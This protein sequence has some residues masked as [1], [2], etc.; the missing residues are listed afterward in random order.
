[1]VI[2][3]EGPGSGAIKRV[4]GVLQQSPPNQGAVYYLPLALPLGSYVMRQAWA[5]ASDGSLETSALATLNIEWANDQLEPVYLGSLVIDQRSKGTA[6]K[7]S[8][9]L[10]IQDAALEDTPAIRALVSELKSANLATR[11]LTLPAAPTPQAEGGITLEVSAG[12]PSQTRPT[13]QPARSAYAKFLKQPLPRAFATNPD[14]SYGWALGPN[15]VTR[16]LEFC[17]RRAKTLH[18]QRR[19]KAGTTEAECELWLV[20]NTVLSPPSCQSALPSGQPG[21]AS[22]PTAGR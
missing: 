14:G 22:C 16:A 13:A 6:I 12:D 10:S 17:Q 19:N 20:D 2:D 21:A 15:A 8:T 4:S 3:V 11:L 1:L 5:V 18:V 9:A 7:G